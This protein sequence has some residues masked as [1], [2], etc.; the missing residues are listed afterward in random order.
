[1]FGRAMPHALFAVLA[2]AAPAPAAV[3]GGSVDD[4]V[5]DSTAGSGADVTKASWAFDPD[6]GRW[7]V[8]VTFASAPAGDDYGVINA[9]LRDASVADCGGAV[10][11]TFRASNKSGGAAAGAGSA[12][13]GTQPDGS[14]GPTYVS[15]SNVKSDEGRTTTLEVAHPRLVGR[16]AACVTIAISNHGVKDSVAVPAPGVPVTPANPTNPDKPGAGPTNPNQPYV[17]PPARPNLKLTSSRTLRFKKGS[18]RI[19]LA[20]ARY[21]LTGK[22]SLVAGKRKV[23]QGSFKVS[24]PVAV[25]ARLFLTRAGASYLRRLSGRRA[26]RVVLVVRS[27]EASGRTT[28]QSFRVRLRR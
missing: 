25:R 4:P 2:L 27:V 28:Q 9:S 6:A 17:V 18:A 1:M 11:A 26:A 14:T 10:F 20:G 3:V 13:D 7:M 22:L 23:A 16:T 21:A 15:G 8:S 24:R 19:T 12:A 5:G